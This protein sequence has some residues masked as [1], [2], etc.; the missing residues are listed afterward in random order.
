MKHIKGII[1]A[2][3]SLL[4]LAGCGIDDELSNEQSNNHGNYTGVVT[5][6]L[7][8]IN[9]TLE[10]LRSDKPDATGIVR[11][12]LNCVEKSLTLNLKWDGLL[13]TTGDAL[14]RICFYKEMS[15]GKALVRTITFRNENSTGEAEVTLP[16]EPELSIG[17]MGALVRGEWSIALCTTKCPSGIIGGT[18]QLGEYDENNLTNPVYV[19]SFSLKDEEGNALP[20]ELN[21]ILEDETP[22]TV[23]V[24]VNPGFADN[25]EYEY[26][27][28][29]SSIFTVEE[30]QEGYLKLTAVN[31]GTANLVITAKDRE[32][33]PASTMIAIDVSH[34]PDL[35]QFV[36]LE[37]KEITLEVGDTEQ[38]VWKVLPETALNKEVVFESD[39]EE[40]ATIDVNGLLTAVGKGTAT[41]TITSKS[42][43]TKKATCTVSCLALTELE[44]TN[45]LVATSG[46]KFH[47]TVQTADK[48]IDG[49]NATHWMNPQNELTAAL[50]INF[51]E[52]KTISR[53]QLDRR[54]DKGTPDSQTT[55]LR[56][57]DVY[58]I[59]SGTILTF[60]QNAVGV[61]IPAEAQ[62]V[63]V[64]D[65]GDT[66][67]TALTG[68]C[69]FDA[70][71]AVGI[72]I[73]TT[74][75]NNAWRAGIS[76]IR[77]YNKE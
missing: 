38:L 40:V 60:E 72:V 19:T 67:N 64:I 5:E 18:L 17:D 47:D 21:M 53:V 74:A 26:M 46:S 10:N 49:N 20:A 41:I 7:Y 62:K 24:V 16:Q 39:N 42:D 73:R 45:W 35:V 69:D 55:A 1:G 29:N 50:I 32:E 25:T 3:F 23:S 61:E 52:A 8:S 66:S 70:T 68:T 48:V 4:M 6:E 2:T 65:F 9:Y 11:G 30:T 71:E 27:S 14:E 76:E 75:G 63:G 31:I 59:P 36:D 15:N 37:Q 13:E 56:T 57:A 54:Y 51:G 33:N 58:I 22:R 28:D 34:S 12:T 44:R 77:A 43:D